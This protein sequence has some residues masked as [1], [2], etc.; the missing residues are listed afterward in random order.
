M[1][2]LLAPLLEKH[3]IPS[4]PLPRAAEISEW[5]GMYEV[6]DFGAKQLCEAEFGRGVILEEQGLHV[7]MCA[8][9]MEISVRW[10]SMRRCG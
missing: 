9:G 10:R 1:R 7:G 5:S 2:I 8:C 3:N 4:N 6:C